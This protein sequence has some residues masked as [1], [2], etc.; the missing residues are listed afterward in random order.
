MNNQ[1]E[2]FALITGGSGL[3][4]PYHAD[5]LAEIGFNIIL[6]DINKSKLEFEK[7]NLEKKFKNIKILIFCMDIRVKKNVQKIFNEISKKNFFVSCLVNNADI[8][9]KMKNSK[10]SNNLESYNEKKIISEIEVGILG[11]FN[12]CT[13][14]G[15]AMAKRKFGSIINIS[16]DL[17]ICAPD[18]RIYSK[19]E[20]I[21]N[22]KSFKP[23]TYSITKHAIG[24][25]TKYIA[26]YWA[27]KNVRC[28]TLALGPVLNKQPPHIIKNVKRRIPLNR[29]AERYEYKKAIQ[30]LASEENSY[31]TGQ[32]LIVDGGRTI[33]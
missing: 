5:A 2:K 25:I 13:I 24:G 20:N 12:F 18:Q 9:P 3:L 16:S 7:K 30:F 27:H 31:M 21:K 22:V 8:N 23:I 1:F 11:T 29:W 19:N 10:I 6:V 15:A 28:N 4:G 14:F 17:G 32:T 33:W 26:T